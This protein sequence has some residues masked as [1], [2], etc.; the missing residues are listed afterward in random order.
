[1]SWA[2]FVNNLL[3]GLLD[4]SRG[5]QASPTRELADQL[6]TLIATGRLEPGQR[7]PSSRAMARALSISRNT[8][9]LVVE[10]LAAEGYL[11]TAH[12]RRPVVA[13]GACLARGKI[14]RYAQS[15]PSRIRLSE[16]AQYLPQSAWPP[17]YA[18]RPRAFQPGLADEREFPHDIWGRCLRRSAGSALR[19]KHRVHNVP[20]L[21]AA[22][23]AHLME[24]RGIKARSE[25]I[26]VVP[27][28]QAAIALI[29]KIIVEPD[30]I[31]WI[32]S[33]GYGGA[34]AGLQSAGAQVVGMPID[35]DGMTIAR[36]RAAPRLIFVTPSHQYP[37]GLLMTVAR[38]LEL[39]EFAN[40]SGATIIEDDYDGEFH[41][42]GRPVAALAGLGLHDQTIYVGTFSKAMTA[43]VRIGYVVVPEGLM[44]PFA[45]AQRHLGLL[46]PVALQAAL[47]DFMASGHYR[48]HVRKMTRLY[49]ERRDR[50][51]ESLATHVGN[52][53]HVCVPAGGMQLLARGDAALEDVE[54]AGRL[55]RA[56]VTTLPLSE[57]IYHRSRE[58]GLFM[59]FAAWNDREIEEGARI[60]GRLL[61]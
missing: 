33:P 9:S 60:I 4:V 43:D 36:G 30:D 44:R 8:V 31:V 23:L 17:A 39:L 38:R 13:T 16:W 24:S 47:A 18:A 11:S 6:R 49:R 45:L 59:G 20:E 55:E 52:R 57:M 61:R 58:R 34:F 37:T 21:Q 22:L 50:L 26:L 54:L 53:L 5:N 15:Q 51:V 27:S 1:M 2:T 28:A 3:S 41:Y 19:K 29:A 25:Q 7:L 35:A 56:G 14:K 48:S 42:D 32:E 40:S 46:V 12:N 10:Q